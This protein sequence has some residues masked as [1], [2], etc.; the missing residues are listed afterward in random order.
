MQDRTG[1]REAPSQLEKFKARFRRARLG[2]ARE[3]AGARTEIVQTV[4]TICPGA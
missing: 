2:P 4:H 1:R 3:V